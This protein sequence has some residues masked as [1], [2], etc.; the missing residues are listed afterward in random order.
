MLTGS[1]QDQE[2]L[3][4]LNDYLLLDKIVLHGGN[5]GNYGLYHEMNFNPFN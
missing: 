1:V 4:W 3:E 2:F 5:Y